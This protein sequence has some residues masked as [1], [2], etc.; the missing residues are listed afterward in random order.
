MSD[1]CMAHSKYDV[2]YCI[3]KSNHK[4]AHKCGGCPK[5]F[6]IVRKYE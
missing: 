4:G 1:Y 2:C 3:L 5:E 6:T